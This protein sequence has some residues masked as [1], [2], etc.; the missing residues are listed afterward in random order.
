MPDTT[1][2]LGKKDFQT[3]QE[4]RWCPGC[5]DYAILSAV[6][7]VFPELGIPREKFVIVSGI[8]CSSRFPYY[9]NTFGFH[10]IHG[11]A[12]AVATGLKL[13]RPELEVWIA[14]GDGDSMSIGGNHLIHVLRRNVGVKILMFNN[15]IYGLTKGQYSPTSE[16]GKRTK[17][18]PVGSVDYPFNPLALA[19]GAGATFVARSVDIFQQ[20]L[21]QT[22]RRAAQHKG[23]AFVE[24]YQNCNIFNDNAFAYMT[25][26][27]SR[28]MQVLE[29]EHGKPLTFGKP[30][31]TAPATKGLRLN[32]TTFDIVDLEGV[33]PAT[34]CSTWDE[35]VDSPAT[36]FLAAQLLPPFFPTPIGVFRN[37]ERPTYESGVSAQIATEMERRGAGKLEDLLRQGDTWTVAPQVS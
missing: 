28:P 31:P 6:Q 34:A 24:I 8:G 11:R 29:L 32:G 26:K 7:Q 16:V 22:L 13:A 9:M 25:D 36:A 37:V 5:G 3:D 2:A 1:V 27:E 35:S 17:S 12:P 18:S 20:H 23:T 19:L 30:T 33:D 21:K 4:V 14:T 10:S 15:R